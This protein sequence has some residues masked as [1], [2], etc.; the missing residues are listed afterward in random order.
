MKKISSLL[1]IA[2]FTCFSAV[3]IAQQMPEQ[4]KAVEVASQTIDLNQASLDDLL[5]LKG[6]GKKR[7]QAI[8]SYRKMNGK[9]AS[10]DDLLKVKGIGAKVLADNI[11]RLKI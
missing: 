8:I 11:Q 7:A 5:S 6:V 4:A 2:L 10:V 3:S 9:F 1:L